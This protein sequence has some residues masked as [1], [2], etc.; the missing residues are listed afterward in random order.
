VRELLIVSDFVVAVASGAQGPE[1]LLAKSKVIFAPEE[2]DVY[3][4]K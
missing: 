3:S 2:R 1:I 4:G